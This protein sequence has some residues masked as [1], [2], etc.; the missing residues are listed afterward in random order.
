MCVCVCVCVHARAHACVCGLAMLLFSSTL[1][2]SLTGPVLPATRATTHVASSNM[3]RSLCSHIYSG[4]HAS[5]R[6]NAPTFSPNTGFAKIVPTRPLALAMYMYM[7][8]Y[9]YLS[10]CVVQD[11]MVDAIHFTFEPHTCICYAG[12]IIFHVHVH[13]YV[14]M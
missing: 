2:T 4:T 10:P 8:M 1:S 3:Q 5:C 6:M 7:Y 9:M 14:H 12:L 13:R 11:V